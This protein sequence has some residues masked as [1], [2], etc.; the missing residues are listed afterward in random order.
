MFHCRDRTI[1]DGGPTSLLIILMS[2]GYS[3]ACAARSV[4]R[5]DA[6]AACSIGSA[7]AAAAMVAHLLIARYAVRFLRTLIP[8]FQVITAL[9]GEASRG[10]RERQGDGAGL[11]CADMPPRILDRVDRLPDGSQYTGSVVRSA[12]EAVRVH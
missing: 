4:F 12:C 1:A 5:E 8:G 6:G 11:K 2:H 3:A 7:D 9:A 10:H